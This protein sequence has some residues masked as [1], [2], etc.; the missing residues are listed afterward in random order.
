MEAVRQELE[1]CRPA[2][3]R[4]SL[5]A[6]HPE[7]AFR[8]TRKPRN[9]QGRLARG[10]VVM[11][12]L[13]SAIGHEPRGIRPSV[14][15]SDPEVV[16]DQRFPLDH[17]RSID[18]RRVRRVFGEMA[19]DERTAIDDEWPLSPGLFDPIGRGSVALQLSDERGK[20]L[21]RVNIRE[22]LLFG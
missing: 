5:Q 15:V 7:T 1:R 8:Q 10:V 18:K 17:I 2:E 21:L 13:D 14:I 4:K 12:D 19:R 20:A 16:S 11:V 9:Q 3:L 6:P 22:P